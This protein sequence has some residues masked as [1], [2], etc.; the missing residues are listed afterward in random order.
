MVEEV[1]DG[2]S[3]K[4]CMHWFRRSAD[5]D[6]GKCRRHAPRPELDIVILRALHPP[7]PDDEPPIIDL[8]DIWGDVTWPITYDCD[9]C[10]EF[11]VRLP[12]LVG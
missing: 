9:G 12:R 1:P 11:A 4:M 2:E 10:G 8:P 3:C 7:S 6:T 5:G